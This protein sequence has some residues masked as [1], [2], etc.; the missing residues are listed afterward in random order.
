MA[1]IG[2]NDSLSICGGAAT[3]G[4]GLCIACLALLLTLSPVSAQTEHGLPLM[5]IH[6]TSPAQ[7][8]RL[9]ATVDVWEV[10]HAAGYVLAPLTLA[11]ER[12]LGR[13]GFVLSLDETRTALARAQAAPS[14]A[15]GGLA[16][17]R[18]VEETYAT[19]DAL[20]ITYPDLARWVDIGDSWEKEQSFG[21]AGYDLR[22]LVISNQ[23]SRAPKAVFYLLAAVHARE[24]TTAESAT[25]FG[26]YLVR[27]YGHDPDVTWLLD[28]NEIHI[29]PLG[30]PDGRKRAEA[31]FLW[32]KNVNSGDGC[33]SQTSL[34]VDLNR[35]GSF[36]W[37]GCGTGN[38]SSGDPCGITF[39]GRAP[40]SEPE[41]QAL[42]AYARSILADQ[43][44]PNDE[45]AAP[46][47]ATGLFISLHSYG[48][49]VLFPWGWTNAESPNLTQLQTLGR[50]FGYLND[51]A[52]CQLSQP[53]CLYRADGTNDDF[54]Y[55]ELGVASYTFELGNYFFE[56]CAAFEETIWPTNLPALLYAA[57]AA[58]RPYQTPSGP[59]VTRLDAGPMPIAPGTELLVEL[60]LDDTR[61]ASNGFGE[62]TAQAVSGWQYSFDAPAWLVEPTPFDLPAL[63]PTTTVST[64][65]PIPTEGLAVGR[66]TL[67]VEGRDAAGNI[68]PPSA[69]FVDITSGRRALAAWAPAMASAAVD[70]TLLV[71]LTVT[72]T[73]EIADEYRV[74]VTDSPWPVTLSSNPLA[75]EPGAAGVVTAHVA[76]P[77]AAEPDGRQ[78]VSFVVYS[79]VEPWVQHELS[80]M[81]E[82]G[83]YRLFFPVAGR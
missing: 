23:A 76:I 2:T 74:S 68:G 70:S 24:L 26:E 44:G 48:E 27:A 65:V 49:L 7:L 28:H 15:T 20:S 58:R 66:H 34:G 36:R 5:R 8:D 6:F 63:P 72:N 10:N 39:R 67:F 81:A 55:G 29:V 33:Y 54:V 43:R 83:Q 69:L 40:G 19:L 4:I 82:I 16:C 50:K 62:E 78:P 71:S 18:T 45:D 77:L 13:A 59:D 46:L 52:V 51:Y 9:A 12:S 3:V 35:N 21:A 37:A 17:Y 80:V 1:L 41:T 47:D 30:N 64:T 79:T 61:Y 75:L 31:G 32:R 42:E 57:K 25:R 73:G 14:M 38:C 53:G 60:T 11:E 56:S 22:A